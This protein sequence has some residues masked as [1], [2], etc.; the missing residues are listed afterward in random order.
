MSS[1]RCNRAPRGHGWESTSL[2]RNPAASSFCT[3]ALKPWGSSGHPSAFIAPSAHHC[4][5][6][7]QE[8]QQPRASLSIPEHP[9]TPGETES[10][11]CPEAGATHPAGKAP[12]PSGAA[13]VLGNLDPK[14]PPHQEEHPEPH[15]TEMQ[16]AERGCTAA[17]LA[18]MCLFWELKP[19]LPGFFQ[20]K[21][22][23]FLW[24][25]KGSAGGGGEGGVFLSP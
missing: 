6:P 24:Q 3:P 5:I 15:T 19:R 1:P 17:G 25:N 16:T 14:P 20:H 9:C 23:T 10:W 18:S 12:N 2:I 7:S 22:T 8:G 4:L 11:G 13:I 21:I